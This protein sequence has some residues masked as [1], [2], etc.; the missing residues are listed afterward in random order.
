LACAAGFRSSDGFVGLLS[1]SLLFLS[2][3]GHSPSF[4]RSLTY[5]LCL[6]I[7]SLLHLSLLSAF[8]PVSVATFSFAV[9]LD[10]SDLL[11]VW[12]LLLEELLSFYLDLAFA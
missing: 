1:S 8:W 10:Q 11:L 4:V 9:S 5:D 12:V 3:C 2:A 6:P 7:V